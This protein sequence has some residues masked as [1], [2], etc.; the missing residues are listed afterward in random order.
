MTQID[1]I[2]MVLNSLG[3]GVAAGILSYGQAGESRLRRIDR[4]F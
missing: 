4:R 2:G 1:V 3:E